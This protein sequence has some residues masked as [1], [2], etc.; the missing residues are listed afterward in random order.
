MQS[1]INYI[2]LTC[3]YSIIRQ[4]CFIPRHGAHKC[5]NKFNPAFVPKKYYGRGGKGGPRPI[6]GIGRGFAPYGAGR[7]FVLTSFIGFN[8]GFN[9]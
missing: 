5:K 7:G 9:G 3:I 8:R 1:Y 4:I 2:K 6:Y